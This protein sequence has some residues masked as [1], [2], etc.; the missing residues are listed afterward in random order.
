MPDV[1]TLLAEFMDAAR[2]G[3]MPEVQPYLERAD[4]DDA[5]REL[6]EGIETFL[7]L[8]GSDV[9]WQRDPV[10]GE[11]D[12][13]TISTRV[14]M[15]VDKSFADPEP[16]PASAFAHLREQSGL[17]IDALATTLMHRS[18][19]TTSEH[20]QASFRKWIDALDRGLRG[21]DELSE[22]ARSAIAEAVGTTTDALSEIKPLTGPAFRAAE[23]E[24]ARPALEALES[25]ADE[26]AKELD[27]AGGAVSEDD[28][29]DG[30][31]VGG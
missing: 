9:R 29:V 5:R 22:R 10:S 30:W 23:S 16:D 7:A 24:V 21:L 8:G 14:K 27:G 18:G 17:T 1:S 31:F 25:A 19:L 6:S 15:L 13:P 4:D 3:R 20:R 12:V 26:M 28:A 2:D 11:L